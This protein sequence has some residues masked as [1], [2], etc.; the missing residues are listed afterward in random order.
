VANRW[1]SSRRWALVLATA[2]TC[3]LL[4]GVSVGCTKPKAVSEINPNSTPE[5]KGLMPGSAGSKI[6][7]EDID[8]AKA[9]A[10]EWEKSTGGK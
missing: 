9:K 4:A 10:D 7:Q 8:K 1:F 6:T 3:A 2:S 5:G